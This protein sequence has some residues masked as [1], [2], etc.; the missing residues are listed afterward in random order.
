MKLYYSLNRGVCCLLCWAKEDIKV[1]KYSAQ[2]AHS[3][4]LLRSRQS[5]VLEDLHL[6]HSAV[7]TSDK[8]EV[9]DVEKKLKSGE[10]ALLTQIMN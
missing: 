4:V 9:E 5:H 10:F 6:T 2:C 8:M 1:Q 3:S 7:T